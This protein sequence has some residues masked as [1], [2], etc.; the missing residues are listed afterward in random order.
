M[1]Q[2]VI[3]GS[4][5][6]L[7]LVILMFPLRVSSQLDLMPSFVPWCSGSKFLRAIPPL[8]KNQ[9]FEQVRYLEL[10]L[11]KCFFFSAL[12]TQ[13]P[14]KKSDVFFNFILQF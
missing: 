9:Q 3:L 14:K 12:F 13:P 7:V 8:H 4:G 6:G 11:L 2:I 10:V 1:N 5:V